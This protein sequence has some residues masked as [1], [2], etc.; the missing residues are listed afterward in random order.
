M[1]TNTENKR[2]TSTAWQR[3]YSWGQALD[4]ALHYSPLEQLELSVHDLEKRLTQ[5]E[6][7]A[8]A[9]DKRSAYQNNG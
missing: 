5:I 3:F 7:D 8:H 1:S 6:S 9:E 2:S 4:A